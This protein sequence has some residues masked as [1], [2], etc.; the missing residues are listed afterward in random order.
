MQ[1]PES[2]RRPLPCCKEAERDATASQLATLQREIG[3][4]ETLRAGEQR[5]FQADSLE[6]LPRT[7]IQA[8]IALGLSQKDLA[9]RLGLK[10]Q[11]IQRYEA[12]DYASASLE[13]VS[14]VIRAMGLKVREEVSLSGPP[15]PPR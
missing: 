14:A 6:E 10:E 3:E 13:R 7:L 9:G 4:Y 2:E 12:T 15:L 11:Q 1:M 5:A 8:R